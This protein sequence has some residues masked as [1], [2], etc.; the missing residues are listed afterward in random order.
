MIETN[1]KEAWF[2]RGRRLEKKKG[3]L[4]EREGDIE[5]S[6]DSVVSEIKEERS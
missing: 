4:N 3:I 5:I 6:E 2:R 1:G